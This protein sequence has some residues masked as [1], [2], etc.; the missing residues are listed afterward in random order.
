MRFCYVADVRWWSIHRN[1]TGL[2]KY[3]GTAHSWD[4]LHAEEHGEITPGTLESYDLVVFGSVPVFRHCFVDGRVPK[5][6]RLA[7]TCASFRDARF[8]MLRDAVTQKE[9]NITRSIHEA[10]VC[11]LVINDRRMTP[12]VASHG[13]PIIYHPDHIDPEVFYPTPDRPQRDLVRVGWAGSEKHWM[14]V[15]H[16][17]LIRQGAKEAD[18]ELVLQRREFEGCKTASEMRDWYGTLDA[19]ISANEELTPNPVPILEALVCGRPVITTRCGEVWPFVQGLEPQLILER[20]A[21]AEITRALKFAR[22]LGAHRLR[23]LGE[24]LG[25]V[26]RQ[27]ITWHDGAAELFTRNMEALCRK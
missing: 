3:H 1:G 18:I 11:A 5:T 16:V 15:K 26:A 17:D 22:R 14:G 7:V 10:G 25:R 6:P 13:L 12:L 24:R 9:I 20:P 8:C 4:V 19:Y 21:L 23:Q 2:Q 27:H